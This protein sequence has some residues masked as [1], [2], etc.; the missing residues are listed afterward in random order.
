MP[1]FLLYGMSEE[2][3]WNCDPREYAVYSK[4]WNLRKQSLNE[5]SYIMGCYVYRAIDTVVTNALNAFSKTSKEP[6]E[7]LT[8]PF[9]LYREKTEE[10]IRKEEEDKT[11]LENDRV[12][13]SLD[14]L[15]RNF[16]K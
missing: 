12:R 15:A 13:A 4:L 2:T 7:Y 16:K 6:K 3:F 10:E 5:D 1:T 11:R 8:K 9:D 14:A